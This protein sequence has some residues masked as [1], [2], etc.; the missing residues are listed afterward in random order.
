MKRSSTLKM[1]AGIFSDTLLQNYQT[2]RSY[3]LEDR[4]LA[5]E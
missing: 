3:I 5:A 1:E 4:H 2:I